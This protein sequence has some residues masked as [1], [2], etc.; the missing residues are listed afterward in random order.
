MKRFRFRRMR[1]SGRHPWKKST[2]I[3]LVVAGI[4]V[5]AIFLF[6]SLRLRPM[7]QTVTS[8]IAKQVSTQAIQSTVVKQL[9]EGGWTYED[10]VNIQRDSSGN[11]VTVTTNMVNINQLKAKIALAIQEELGERYTQTGVPL[12]TLTGSDLLRGYGP[13]VPVR[14]SVAGNVAVDLKSNF[15]AAGINQ[16]RHQIYL[17]IRTNVYS[18]LTGASSTTDVTTDVAV[19]ETVIVGDVPQ[20]FASVGSDSSLETAL[21]KLLGGQS[22]K[23]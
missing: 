15:E 21:G 6:V 5:L 17:E 3:K 7:I 4:L 18:Y 14:I 8:T 9:E 10:F 22:T 2:K 12:G 20:M 19:A 23:K 13:K 11:I 16:T 1:R